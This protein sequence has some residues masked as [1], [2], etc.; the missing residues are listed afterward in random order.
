MDK[1]QASAAQLL[2]DV[3]VMRPDYKCRHPKLPSAL[4]VQSGSPPSSQQSVCEKCKRCIWHTLCQHRRGKVIAVPDELIYSKRGPNFELSLFTHTIMLFLPLD[5]T[6]RQRSLAKT[7][8]DR[9]CSLVPTITTASTGA[10]R[11]CLNAPVISCLLGQCSPYSSR[12]R[13]TLDMEWPPNPERSV[14]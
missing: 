4:L 8:N 7:F 12:P 14:A 6:L 10:R 13:D 3:R 9:I 11:S 5:F 1:R 2:W